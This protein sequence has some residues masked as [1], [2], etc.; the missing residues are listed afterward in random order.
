MPGTFQT[1][2]TARL[3]A[4][5]AGYHWKPMPL[6]S[7]PTKRCP[8]ETSLPQDIR[9]AGPGA[10][11]WKP[12]PQGCWGGNILM[13]SARAGRSLCSKRRSRGSVPGRRRSLPAGAMLKAEVCHVLSPHLAALDPSRQE[14]F[15]H[16]FA[17]THFDCTVRG[18]DFW[19]ARALTAPNL[20]PDQHRSPITAGQTQA[21]E[22]EAAQAQPTPPGKTDLLFVP[23]A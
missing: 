6:Q 15:F 2:S 19:K 16:R 5:S 10:E 3:T 7:P 12:R 11:T 13:A 20:C 9:G 18:G 4:A 21:L 8:W 14:G 1:L 23:A 17:N 22:R